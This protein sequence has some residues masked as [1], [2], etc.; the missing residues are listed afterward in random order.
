MTLPIHNHQTSFF[1]FGDLSRQVIHWTPRTCAAGAAGF[2]SLGIA[3]E[4]GLMAAIDRIA[5]QLLRY[6]VGYM[7]LGAIM[8]TF[9]WYSAW[10]VRLSAALLAG[11]AYDITERIVLYTIRNF[12]DP[13]HSLPAERRA[14]PPFPLKK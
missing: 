4:K 3:Y 2:Y 13:S 10:G 11:L 14:P 1:S 12:I 7:G 5:I 6:H 9:Q 8:P